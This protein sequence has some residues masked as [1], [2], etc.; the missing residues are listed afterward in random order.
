VV[1]KQLTQSRYP[2]YTYMKGRVF[3]YSRKVPSDLRGF[4]SKPRIVLSLRTKSQSVAEKA[5]LLMTARL[6]EYWLSLRMKKLDVPGMQHINVSLT[7]HE[8]N[9]PTLTDALDLYLELKGH[10]KDHLFHNLTNRNIGYLLD[11]LGNRPLD[12]Y[13]T[14]DAAAFRQYLVDKRMASSTVK[15]VFSTI[16]AIVNLAISEKGLDISNPFSGVYLPNK[17]DAIKRQ[18]V[19]IENIHRLKAECLSID[20]D[21]RWIVALIIDTGMRLS[22]ALGLMVDNLVLDHEYPHLKLQPHPHR[23]LKT[24]DSQRV[25]PLVGSSLW[26]AKRVS[27]DINFCFPRYASLE[28]CNSNSASAAL[29]KWI[30]NVCG[31][32]VVIHGLRHSFRDRL[33]QEQAPT[34]LIDQLGGWSFRSV[35]QNYGR[36]YSLKVLSEWM[37]KIG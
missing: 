15:R 3:Y 35:G 21:L 19:S 27:R 34:E 36:G 10:G 30:K 25:I 31:D 29:N 11:C 12:L 32:G 4:Y 18:P 33:R 28:G 22:E 26:A 16:K 13:S 17:N 1:T 8:S 14:A 5:S 2:T 7:G 23:G 24:A 6:E 37:N 20:D 9:Q